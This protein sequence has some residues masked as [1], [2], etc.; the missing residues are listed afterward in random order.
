MNRTELKEKINGLPLFE[1]REIKVKSFQEGDE[2]TKQD[3]KFAICETEGDFAYAFVGKNYFLTQFKDVFN[4]ILDSIDENMDG[5][6]L[7]YGG[8]AMLK[9]FPERDDLKDGKSKFGLVAM[10]SVD[11][12]SSIIVK[13]CVEH[14]DLSFTIPPRVA[15][16]KKHHTGNAGNVV[17]NYI[18]MIGTVKEA[19]KKI[20]TEFPKVNVVRDIKTEG[21]GVGKE[22]ELGNI[23]KMFKTG[24]KLS[25]KINKEYDRI[26]GEGHT[27]NLWDV[28]VK[29]LDEMS[30]V[31][32]KSE[33]HKQKH[34]DRISKAVFDYAVLLSL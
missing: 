11:L 16:I 33:T 12:S 7:S 26:I 3:K 29:I 5:Y 9:V 2:W 22:L 31:N 20:A 4:P 23:F 13:F 34:I 27:Y 24:K 21:I 8:F 14:G 15:G 25:K 19:W 17:K 10:N 18:S 28:V 30:K 32:H 6:L 1:K